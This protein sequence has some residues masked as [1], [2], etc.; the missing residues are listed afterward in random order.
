MRS[1][2]PPA[3]VW[4]AAEARFRLRRNAELRFQGKP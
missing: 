4:R 2:Y 1:G 3:F